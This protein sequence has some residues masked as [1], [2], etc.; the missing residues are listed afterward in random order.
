M[1]ICILGMQWGDEG[2]GKITDIISK[3]SDITV[4]FCGGA[5][6]GHTIYKGGEKIVAHILPSSILNNKVC[7]LGNSMVIHFP[8]LIK[9]IN[10]LRSAW[11]ID[12]ELYISDKAHVVL[13]VYKEL[14]KIIDKTNKIGTTHKGI[15]PAYT[16]KSKRIGIQTG[17]L[18]KPNILYKSLNQIN[19]DLKLYS[20]CIDIEKSMEY[21]GQISRMFNICD[22]TEILSKSNNIVI[23]GSQGVMLDIDNGTYPYVTSCNTGISGAIAGTGLSHKKIDRIIGVVKSYTTRVGNGPFPTEIFSEIANNIREKG[24]EYGAT[25]GR[26]RRIGWLDLDQVKKCVYSNGV[27]IINLTKLDVLSDIQPIKIKINDRYRS[28]DGFPGISSITEFK[29]LPKNAVKCIQAIEDYLKI[30]IK[31]I[32]TGVDTTIFR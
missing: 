24:A 3:D 19:Q 18:D 26:P 15:G 25:T 5:N 6:A 28:L 20:L 14:D 22:I 7:V 32:G 2:K 30:P 12:I 8:S 11:G 4:R 21:F 23:E 31:Y 10:H 29:E 27:D 17:Y 13:D 9:E 16:F 1:N